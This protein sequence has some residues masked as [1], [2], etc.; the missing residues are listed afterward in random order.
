[1]FI[2][3]SISEMFSLSLVACHNASRETFHVNVSSLPSISELLEGMGEYLEEKY[4]ANFPEIP[5]LFLACDDPPIADPPIAIVHLPSPSVTLPPEAPLFQVHRA[6]TGME[7]ALEP[8]LLDS[9]APPSTIAMAPPT[10]TALAPLSATASSSSSTQLSRQPYKKK[11]ACKFCGEEHTYSNL[12]RHLKIHAKKSSWLQ[13]DY[14]LYSTPRKD[15]LQRH[16]ELT[17]R[18]R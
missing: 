18:S 8:L 3:S 7:P 2:R 1:M 10:S 5:Q 4:G 15:D 9:W 13:C 16:K 6:T 12:A 14:C 17:H 11:V